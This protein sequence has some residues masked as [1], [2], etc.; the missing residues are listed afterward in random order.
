[1]P[2]SRSAWVTFIQTLDDFVDRASFRDLGPV[3]GGVNG[4]CSEGF[5]GPKF[6]Q[7]LSA[8]VPRPNNDTL[9]NWK[10]V[11]MGD[12]LL[13]NRDN[14]ATDSVYHAIGATGS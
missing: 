13:F 5:E 8:G 3:E 11:M 10:V 14:F 1:M 12:G 4:V 6:V 9:A 2:V 7:C